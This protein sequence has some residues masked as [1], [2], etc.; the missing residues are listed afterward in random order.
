MVTMA[1]YS[2]TNAAH[3]ISSSATTSGVQSPPPAKLGTLKL[4]SPPPAKLAKLKLPSLSSQA[5]VPQFKFP[6]PSSHAQA[7]E[8]K[9]HSVLCM[10]VAHQI[11]GSLHFCSVRAPGA[12]KRFFGFGGSAGPSRSE[13]LFGGSAASSSAEER[14]RDG[15]APADELRSVPHV[16][17]WLQTNATTLSAS[18]EAERIKEVVEEELASLK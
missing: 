16:K 6:S 1:K 4:P 7:P 14:A 8:L 17:M 10:H 2:P 11:P 15:P 9:L 3:G 12:M 5:E 13:Q 18:A